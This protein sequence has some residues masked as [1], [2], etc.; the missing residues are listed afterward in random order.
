[1]TLNQVLKRIESLALGH[2]QV[3]T[4][5]KGLV[6][7]FFTDKKT[8]YPAVCLQDQGGNISLSG[9]ATTLNY[10]LF[11]L[12]L[13]NVSQETKVNE[14]EVLSDTVSIAQDLLAQMNNGNYDD[15]KISTDNNLQLVVEAENDMPAGC[16]IDFSV[17]IMYEQNICQIPTDITDYTPTD[18]DMKYVYDEPYVATGAEGTTL[19]IPAIVGKKVL[20]ITR[21]NAVIYKTS[22][23]PSSSEF[24]WND[25]VIV[26]GAVTNPNERFLIL[27]RNY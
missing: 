18:N 25:T 24:T 9:H 20:F 5:R 17:R 14:N 15:W 7:D 6:T 4:F 8:K 22:S 3:R 23:A 13:V 1:M 12:D 2:R 27:Y 26:L 10:R 11:I 21:G 19:S 16:V